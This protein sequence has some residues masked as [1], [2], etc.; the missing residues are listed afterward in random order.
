M[1][2]CDNWKMKKYNSDNFQGRGIKLG[3]SGIWEMMAILWKSPS[4]NENG[5][6]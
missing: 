5:T 3:Q 2:D 6:V 1:G 4:A